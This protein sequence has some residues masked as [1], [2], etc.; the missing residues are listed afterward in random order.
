MERQP[1]VV[2]GAGLAGLTAANHLLDDGHPVTVVETRRSVGGRARTDTVD[3]FRL[4]LGPHA[5]YRS[6]PA[7]SILERLG[8]EVAGWDVP[9]SDSTAAV[10][11]RHTRLPVGP[12]SLLGTR[13]LGLRGKLQIG[14][15]LG[16]LPKTEA[17]AWAS[18]SVEDWIASEVPDPRAGALVRALARLT[19]YSDRPDISSAGALIEQLQGATDGGVRYLH[20]GW[21]GLADQ[22]LARAL[23]LG[24]DVRTGRAVRSIRPVDGGFELDTGEPVAASAVVLAI[25]PA[26]AD[27][28]LGGGTG[29]VEAAGPEVVA[30]VLDLGLDGL[31]PR[32]FVLGI[33]R[34]H[35]LS[36]H[37]PSAD[38]APEGASL[39]G[40]M[41]YG[42]PGEGTPKETRAELLEMAVRSGI[43]PH[44]I[45]MDRYLHRVVV[46]GGTCLAERG[47]LAGRPG[48]AV[49]GNPGVFV[50]GDWV[51]DEGLLADAAVASGRAAAKSATRA[52]S[53][54]AVVGTSGS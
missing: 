37:A 36:R 47:G 14:R 35:Y 28:L 25:P 5:L 44:Q 40:V 51:G 19:T 49:P 1:V 20:G 31:P 8:I 29:L 38:L 39:V 52:A 53:G 10:G 26:A 12:A 32:R 13:L 15:L 46:A 7:M 43:T 22:L 23:G 2:V 50:A 27:R 16:S 54:A 33:D 21:Q 41:R 11:D 17:S 4:N 3:G 24:A 45:V 6:G 9:V 34:P 48:V 30:S 42:E 18:T